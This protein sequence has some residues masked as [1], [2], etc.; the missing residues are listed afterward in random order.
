MNNFYD[1]AIIGAGT[2]G[3]AALR[4]VR[5][6][7]E[8]F[9]IINDGPYGTTCARV[10]CMPS[11]ALI[12]AS[13]AYHRR[14]VFEDFGIH[15]AG[16]LRVD[17]PAVMQRV[18]RLRDEFVAGARRA[19]E[20]LGER[21]LPG[22]AR[23]LAPDRLA[24]GDREIRA[25][26]IVVAAGSR[27]VVPDLWGALGDRLLTSDSLFEQ[28][29]L[30]PRMAVVGLGPL[31]VE[32]AQALARLGIEISAFSA[33]VSIGGLSDP[34]VI[35]AAADILSR[36]LELHRETMVEPGTAQQHVRLRREGA[37]DIVVDKLLAAL[38]RRPNLDGLELERLGLPLDADGLP[39]FDRQTLQVGTLPVFIAGDVNGRLPLLHEAAD[40]GYIAGRNATAVTADC[41]QRRAPLSIVFT[42]PEI[43]V[44]GRRFADLPQRDVLIGDVD[45]ER[46]GRARLAAHNQ[47]KLRLYANPQTGR[48]IGAELCAPDGAHLAHLLALAMQQSL[49]VRQMLEMPFYHPVLEEGV[50]SAL[51]KLS[52]QLPTVAESD[53]AGCDDF[54]IDALD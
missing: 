47:G 12:E 2:A 29:N 36:E 52:R 23:F 27:P 30:P 46:Q 54:N 40:D 45:F 50:R 28:R 17:M 35:D 49:T 10:G 37:A 20:D 39:P 34:A 13:K 14:T 41:Y 6:A 48:L 33:D 42:D 16:Q 11:K 51:R 26:R 4:E 9:I 32:M 43:A 15:G 7:T 44:V 5:K 18:R 22:R 3:L 19:T 1:V 38:G 21:N 8:N 53:L 25:T 31:G 24:V